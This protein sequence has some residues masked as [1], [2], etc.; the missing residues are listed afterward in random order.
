MCGLERA[1][2]ANRDQGIGNN[3]HCFWVNV[4]NFVEN[5]VC[6]EPCSHLFGRFY[7]LLRT[8]M[9]K[10]AEAIT[11]V[12]FI[13]WILVLCPPPNKNPTVERI[14]CCCCEPF[15][16]ARTFVYRHVSHVCAEN[17]S[18]LSLSFDG[19][20]KSVRWLLGLK[21]HSAPSHQMQLLYHWHGWVTER[22]DHTF[23]SLLSFEESLHWTNRGCSWQI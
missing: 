9:I 21:F 13:S 17:C 19:P 23:C 11:V 16:S 8:I 7:G 1:S 18:G 22:K 3:L 15:K 4:W 6:C 2:I 12:V 20:I 5:G 10:H 14:L